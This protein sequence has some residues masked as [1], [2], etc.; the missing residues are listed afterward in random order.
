M[1]SKET[2]SNFF[3]FLGI[4]SLKRILADRGLPAQQCAGRGGN[5]F[6][7]SMAYLE[8]AKLISISTDW[9]CIRKWLISIYD[10]NKIP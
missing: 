2:I 9:V 3:I 4:Y 5:T 1:I 7:F 10:P 8:F 6:R